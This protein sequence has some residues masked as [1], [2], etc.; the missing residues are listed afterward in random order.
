M[1]KLSTEK[2]AQILHGIVEANSLRATARLTD[3]AINTV[4][5]LM[6]DASK[7]CSEYQDKAMRNLKCKRL[8][9]DDGRL[10][11][12]KKRTCL[13]RKNFK[14]GAMFGLGRLGTRKPNS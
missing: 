7:A 5:N 10:W 12:A 6:I 4:V 13:K 1:N 2:R 3:T 9:F 8:Q 14:G 11:V